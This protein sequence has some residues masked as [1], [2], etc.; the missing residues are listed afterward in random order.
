MSGAAAAIRPEKQL[1]LNCARTRFDDA[2][3]QGTRTLVRGDLDWAYLSAAADVHSVTP[4]FCRQ[5]QHA[6]SAGIPE[7]TWSELREKARRNAIRVLYLTTEL[8]RIVE[9]FRAGGV[10]AV[11]YKGPVTAA[12]AYGDVTLRQFDDLDIIVRQRDLA[13]ASEVL[14][15]LGYHDQ[16]PQKTSPGAP[17]PGEYS[18]VH[19]AGRSRLELHTERTM[20]HFP[21]PIDLDAFRS[22]LAPVSLNGRDLYTFRPEDA[23]PFLCVHGCKDFWGRLAWV[24]DVAEL[25]QIEQGVDWEAAFGSARRL[26]AERMLDLGLCLAANLLDAALPEPI[27]RRLHSNHACGLLAASVRAW[28]LSDSPAVMSIVQR[29]LYRMRMTEKPLAGVRYWFR[30]AHRA[31]IQE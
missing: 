22:R 18:F 11:P 23:L 1:L 20:R 27:V 30:L 6:G 21:V 31:A 28:L 8:V 14:A 29:S 17:V 24:A 15:S 10:L 2:R 12:Q 16:F 7:K 25:A 19:E 13:G 3:A 26:G 4:L 9:G 5:L